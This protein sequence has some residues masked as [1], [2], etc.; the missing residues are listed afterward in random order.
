MT[1]NEEGTGFQSFWGACRATG[2]IVRRS[3][4]AFD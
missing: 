4:A 2:G 3:W 1:Y